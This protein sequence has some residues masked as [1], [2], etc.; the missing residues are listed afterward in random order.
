[1]NYFALDI[2]STTGWALICDRG[3][4]VR[5]E[6]LCGSFSCKRLDHPEMTRRPIEAQ[7]IHQSAIIMGRQLRFLLR[8]FVKDGIKP[9]VAVVEDLI[10]QLPQFKRKKQ[11]NELFASE[12]ETQTAGIQARILLSVLFGAAVGAMDQMGLST[13]AP[14]SVSTWR[15]GFIGA[16]RA[17]KEIPRDKTSQ[18][19]K[20]RVR[21]KADAIGEDLGFKVRNFD[22]SDGLGLGLHFAASRGSLG[23][24]LAIRGT[25]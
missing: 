11:G 6:V 22:E 8:S 15:K 12:P 3:D 21:D 18:W 4:D 17:P 13:A 16:A 5:L 24:T 7:D 14:I 23:A 10:R 9:D 1:M 25:V 20:R 2:A 19:L